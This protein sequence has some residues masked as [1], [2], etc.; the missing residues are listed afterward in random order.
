M[1]D[2]LESLNRARSK[3]GWLYGEKMNRIGDPFQWVDGEQLNKFDNLSRAQR[4][5]QFFSLINL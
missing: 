3:S 5:L 2:I 1:K 4:F